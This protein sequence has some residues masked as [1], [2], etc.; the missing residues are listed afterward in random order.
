MTARRRAA[1]LAWALA[2]SVLAGAPAP[3]AR[4]DDAALLR[5][6]LTPLR[7]MSAAFRQRVVEDGELVEELAGTL[8]MRRPGRFT[9]LVDSPDE[10]AI[11][12]D[13][14]TLW[15]YDAELEQVVISELGERAASHSAMALI[16]GRLDDIGE[17]YAVRRLLPDTDERMRFELRPRGGDGAFD[18]IVLAFF[19]GVPIEATMR[20]ALGQ[21]VEVRLRRVRRNPRIP[22]SAFRFQ[23]PPG[24]EVLRQ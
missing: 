2:L 24:V 18:L 4:A 22:L 11:I 19:Q 14:R 13:G 20:S 5:E 12:S 9:W 16:S 8:S 1:T 15:R 3:G 17:R 7:S 6:L 21:A 10:Q 23:L